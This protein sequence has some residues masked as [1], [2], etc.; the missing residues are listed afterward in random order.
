MNPSSIENCLDP[1]LRLTGQALRP[2][3]KKPT[4]QWA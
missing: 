4:E 3:T 2:A 1:D